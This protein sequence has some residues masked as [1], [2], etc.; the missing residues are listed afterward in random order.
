MLLTLRTP[1]LCA[2]GPSVHR[3]GLPGPQPRRPPALRRQPGFEASRRPRLRAGSRPALPQAECRQS[4]RNPGRPS[5]VPEES[6]PPRWPRLSCPAPS[7]DSS[8]FGRRIPAPG[9][10]RAEA[11]DRPSSARP[12]HPTPL[13]PPHSCGPGS[14]QPGPGRRSPSTPGSSWSGLGHRLSVRPP[15]PGRSAGQREHR[16]TPPPRAVCVSL[17]VGCSLSWFVCHT[18]VARALPTSCGS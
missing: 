2:Q 5:R 7:P 8:C 13:E 4:G 10:L 14:L 1:A 3:A 18:R 15:P 6:R 11:M 9:P 12:P 16:K 17:L